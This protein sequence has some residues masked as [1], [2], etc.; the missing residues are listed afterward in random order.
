M[1]QEL[2]IS[3][4]L[5]REIARPWAG[6]NA[7]LAEVKPLH[8]GAISTTVALSMSDGKRA[9]LKLTQHRVDRSYLYES[10]QL[11]MMRHLGIPVPKIYDC[12]V[13]SLE[14]PFSYL[15]MEYVDGVD[16]HA[17][18]ELCSP[19]QYDDLQT[20]LAELLLRL[21]QTTAQRYMRVNGESTSFETWPAFYR[22]VFD[23]I[24]TDMKDAKEIPLKR[25][26]IMGKLHERLDEVLSHE[27][28][29]RLTHWDV[30]A[31]NVLA[32]PDASGRWRVVSLLDPNC[33]FAH[34]EAEIAYMEL[35]HTTTPAFMKAYQ[36]E[37]KL[38]AEYYD[39]R[40]PVYQM[41]SL[42][43]H[44]HFFGEHYLRPLLAAVDNV[45]RL[46]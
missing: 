15:L 25:R 46:V 32:R 18:H 17:A 16:L 37:R 34:V 23:P 7:E 43:D 26:K 6:D 29:P 19:D 20:H 3:W 13:G 11:T 36:Q 24:W 30:W 21:H 14:K 22:Q 31:T 28:C 4:P 41:Y 40:K 45:A 38:E 8:G 1:S 5:L 27:D 10:K 44:V 33:K 35:F 42:L 9:V 12:T 2:D 39:V